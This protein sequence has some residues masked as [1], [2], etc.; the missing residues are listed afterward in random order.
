MRCGPQ[1]PPQRQGLAYRPVAIGVQCADQHAQQRPGAQ[2]AKIYRATHEGETVFFDWLT[3]PYSPGTVLPDP[4]FRGRIHFAGF[5]TRAQLLDLLETEIEGRQRQVARYRL[6]DR[7]IDVLP[8]SGYDV[9][10]GSLVGERMHQ[11]GAATMDLHIAA[12]IQVRDDVLRLVADEVPSDIEA[13][14]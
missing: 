10:L 12:T 2:D 6:R 11:L 14:V 5:L 8:D 3:S 1:A 9:E 4:E 7:S 13:R